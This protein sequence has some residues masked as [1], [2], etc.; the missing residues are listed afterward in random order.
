MNKMKKLILFTLVVLLTLISGCSYGNYTTTG[1]IQ[2]STSSRMSMS[3]LKFDG[4]RTTEMN[5][6]EGEKYQV[7]VSIV[8]EEGKLGLTVVR[9]N[10]AKDDNKASNKDSEIIYQAEDIATSDF[11]INLDQPGKYKI[12][13]TGENHKGKFKITWEKV[14]K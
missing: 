4:Y 2:I 10:E 5:I 6:K 9:E 8:S 12:T 14:N 1:A 13:V 3:Y 7:D 11:K